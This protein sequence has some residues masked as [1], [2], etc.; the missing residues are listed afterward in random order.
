MKIVET[1]FVHCL[2]NS[3]RSGQPQ[4]VFGPQLKNCQIQ[5][6]FEPFLIKVSEFRSGIRK[7]VKNMAFSIGMDGRTHT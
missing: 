7:L 3:L 5:R 2:P 4:L 6:H 1:T